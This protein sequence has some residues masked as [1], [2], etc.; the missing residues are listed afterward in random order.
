MNLFKRRPQPPSIHDLINA[1][2]KGLPAP[3]DLVVLSH[4]DEESEMSV[5]ALK[6]HYDDLKN[7]PAWQHFVGRLVEIRSEAVKA[8]VRGDLDRFGNDRTDELRAAYGVIEQILSIPGQIASRHARAEE[9]RFGRVEA[10]LDN[11]DF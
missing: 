7:H 2:L 6:N 4:R 9:I 10:N 11:N 1:A 5:L 8:I 3:E